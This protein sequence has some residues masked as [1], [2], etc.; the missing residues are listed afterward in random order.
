MAIDPKTLSGIPDY[1]HPGIERWIEQ[2][3]EPGN[4]LRAVFQ[5]DMVNAALFADDENLVSFRA[6]ALFLTNHAPNDCWGDLRT[7]NKWAKIK[8]EERL[9]RA[10]PGGVPT[11]ILDADP[12]FGEVA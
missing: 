7:Y 6:Y 4:F 12:D 8:A 5:N 9:K 2:G 11:V 3:I 1:M 10:Y